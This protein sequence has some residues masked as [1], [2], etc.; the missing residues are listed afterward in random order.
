[1]IGLPAE[2]CIIDYPG[3]ELIIQRMLE[4]LLV[5]ALRWRSLGNE[6][7]PA[8]LLSGMQI[9]AIARA[10]QAIHADVRANWTVAELASIAGMSRSTFSAQF[11]DVL[12]CAPIEYLMRWRMVIAKDALPRGSKT[13]QRIAEEIG[14][15]ST[16]AFS[17]AFRKRLGC[18]PGQFALRLETTHS[19]TNLAEP[20]LAL[21]QA[22]MDVTFSF[23]STGYGARPF[24][25][26]V[27]DLPWPKQKS[28]P[29]NNR[30]VPQSSQVQAGRATATSGAHQ[31]DDRHAIPA[32][33]APLSVHRTP[34]PCAPPAY[35]ARLHRSAARPREANKGQAV[36]R[37]PYRVAEPFL[38]SIASALN[39][40]GNSG[41]I[42]YAP[43]RRRAHH[44]GRRVASNPGQPYRRSVCPAGARLRPYPVGRPTANTARRRDL[45]PANVR[46]VAPA[47]TTAGSVHGNYVGV[48]RDERFAVPARLSPRVTVDLALRYTVL[49]ARRSGEEPGLAATLTVDNLFDARPR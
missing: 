49:P 15:E 13:L 1:L 19:S 18:P 7:V 2:E 43:H 27:P 14:Y 44:V 10:L 25:E 22:G 32:L 41:L 39:N 17:T 12:G 11:G 31:Q 3:K 8:G 4:A 16:S 40:P 48:L 6:A 36:R 9:P 30:P 42:I 21:A 34:L 37:A 28:G 38:R 47:M 33:P 23:P 46:A 35:S 45:Q 26:T 24:L 5:E 20:I 29:S